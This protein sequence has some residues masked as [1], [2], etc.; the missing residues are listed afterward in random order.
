MGIL[1][2]QVFGDVLWVPVAAVVLTMMFMVV[3]RTIHSPAGAN[4]LIMVHHQAGFL[5]VLSPV[6]AGVLTLFVVAMV[7][8]RFRPGGKYPM[9]WC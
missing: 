3:T 1:C 9:R 8:N 7:W 2:Y 6:G 4:P 5:S